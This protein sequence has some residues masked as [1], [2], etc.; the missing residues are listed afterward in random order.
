MLNFIKEIAVDAGKI[1]SD[2][3]QKNDF[4]I[5]HKGKI[6]LITEVDIASEKLI[7]ER[8]RKKF[9]EDDILAEEGDYE[10]MQSLRKWIIDPLDGTTN[11]SH[12]FPFCAVSIALEIDNQIEFG[13]VYNPIMKEFFSAQK[14]KG[15]FL[16][17]KPLHVSKIDRLSQALIA[18]GFPYDRWEKGDEYIKEYLA[19]MK[20]CQGVRRVGAAAIDL[21]YVASGRLDGFFERKLKPWDM[22]AGSLVIAESGGNISRFD[23][24]KWHYTDQ[25]IIASNSSIHQQ[26]IE[27][28]NALK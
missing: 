22:A 13:V 4:S 26:M 16:N 23:G 28:L 5:S 1:I 24:K 15:V 6:D 8:I 18:T 21:C 10:K 12:H 20:R 3:Y 25:T 11:F 14:G 2:A 9:P 19:F 27:V 7:T 17:G